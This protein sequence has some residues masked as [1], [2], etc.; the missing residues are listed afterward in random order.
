MESKSWMDFGTSFN[1]DCPHLERTIC[2]GCMYAYVR[3][4]W[5]MGT[6]I[7]CPECST[8][9]S[10]DAIETILLNNGDTILYER[11]IKLNFERSLE[12]NP[13]F[14]WCAHGCGSGQLREGPTVNSRIQC[15]YCHRL[16]CFTHKCPWHEGVT[17]KEYGM[18]QTDRQQHA[19]QRWIDGH[20]KKCPKCHVHIE[21]NAGCD[22]MTCYKCKYEFCWECF[23]AYATIRR[24][25]DYLHTR[26]CKNYP[27]IET[28][29]VFK[30]FID[31]F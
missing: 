2:D 20:T 18:P 23:V 16:T 5:N 7:Q 6:D 4:T 13:D 26:K 28:R 3:S 22:H 9:L 19:N 11:Y 12:N 25:G 21:K 30:R 1:V 8:L 31:F 29:N 27:R 10:H 14:V 17:C 24:R 15:V